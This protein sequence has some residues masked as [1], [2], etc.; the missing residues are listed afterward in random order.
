M[1]RKLLVVFAIIVLGSTL[2]FY[3]YYLSL[4]PSHNSSTSWEEYKYYI[5]EIPPRKSVSLLRLPPLNYKRIMSYTIETLEANQGISCAEGEFIEVQFK[6]NTESEFVCLSGIFGRIV[7]VPIEE[8]WNLPQNSTVY[9]SPLVIVR[10]PPPIEINGTEYV[11]GVSA[12]YYC[13][14]A[15]KE[16][17]TWEMAF[18][19]P[20]INKILRFAIPVNSSIIGEFK[21]REVVYVLDVADIE[22]DTLVAEYSPYC[23]SS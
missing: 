20:T 18:Y 7:D 23:I 21:G 15:R 3:H 12:L 4:S 14:P 6:N 10:T 17:R 1:N 22:N 13:D 2:L 8:L 11:I 16:R 9:Y 19:Y 5:D